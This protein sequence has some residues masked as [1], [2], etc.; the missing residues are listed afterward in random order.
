[1]A[2]RIDFTKRAAKELRKLKKTDP[3]AG[4]KI[5]LELEAITRLSN[6]RSRGKAMTGNY[7]GYWRYRVGDY[8]VICDIVDERLLILAVD[9]GHR[10]EIYK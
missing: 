9:L 3:Q 8:R 10:R 1:M 4:E 6:P 2:W 7:S 5:I